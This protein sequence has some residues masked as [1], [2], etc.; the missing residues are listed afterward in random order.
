MYSTYEK[1]ILV[2][3][4]LFF[5]MV[6]KKGLNDKGKNKKNLIDYLSYGLAEGIGL[7]VHEFYTKI[8]H[9]LFFKI[10]TS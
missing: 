1:K 10:L 3:F 6:K 8:Y 9:I 7:H 2:F 4:F 5:N